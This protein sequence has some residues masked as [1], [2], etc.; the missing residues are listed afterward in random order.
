MSDENESFAIEV[1]NIFLDFPVMKSTIL[2]IKEFLLGR[3]KN[4]L[5]RR[6]YRAI[7]NLS[8]K[9]RKG[10]VLGIIGPNGSGKSTLLRILA[11]IY[12]PE[13]GCVKTRGRISLLAGLG[14]GFQSNLTGRDNIFLS[15][16][17]YGIPVKD[18]KELVPSILEYAGIGSF[19]DQPLR[20]YSSGM[21]ARLAFSIVSHME[22][23]I[24]L[25]DE[26]IA[27][28]DSSFKKKSMKRIN[29]LASGE[30]TVVIVSHSQS[31]LRIIC[32]RILCIHDGRMDCLT[33]DKEYAIER[34]HELSKSN[35]K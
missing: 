16:S 29:E 10:E 8:F 17:I 2:T 9:V 12:V 4:I 25:I 3:W 21:R 15:G 31:L 6:Y 23:D 32:D 14:A 1:E 13:R 5:K 34:Y 30:S 18:L 27:V 35:K 22:P 24:L 19:I 7:D 33:E 26:V 11:G 28:G 20:T